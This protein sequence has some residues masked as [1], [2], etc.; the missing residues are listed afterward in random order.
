MRISSMG[1]C[2][3]CRELGWIIPIL[4]RVQ[5]ACLTPILAKVLIE[6][7][8]IDANASQGEE[9]AHLGDDR[10]RTVTQEGPPLGLQRLDVRRQK[11]HLLP[12]ALETTQQGGWEG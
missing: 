4:H 6:P 1:G 5:P 7:G 9:L 2:S 12:R 10:V 8:A 11:A 3:A